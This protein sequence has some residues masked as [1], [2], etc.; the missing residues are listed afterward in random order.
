M[1]ILLLEISQAKEAGG[2]SRIK[3]TDCVEI[4]FSGIA[5]NVSHLLALSF[6]VRSTPITLDLLSFPHKRSL[7]L[8]SPLLNWS[9]LHLNHDIS[10]LVLEKEGENK[11]KWAF[12]VKWH[13]NEC[14]MSEDFKISWKYNVKNKGRSICNCAGAVVLFW[15]EL[16]SL[17]LINTHLNP[18]WGKLSQYLVSSKKSKHPI[19]IIIAND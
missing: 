12:Q 4:H 15:F 13:S 7:S 14:F 11:Y 10:T 8:Y 5:K 1:L 19:P 3:N 16:L 17:T 2:Y 6:C 18:G 9:I